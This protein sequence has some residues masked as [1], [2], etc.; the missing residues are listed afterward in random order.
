[1]QTHADQEHSHTTRSESQG[2]NAT[3]QFADQRPAAA[4]Q[5]RLANLAAASPR[6]AQ[7][8]AIQAMADPSPGVETTQRLGAGQMATTQRLAAEEEEPLQGKFAVAQRAAEEDE[9]PVQGKFATVQRLAAEE[10]EPLQGKFAIAQ[11]EAMEDEEPVQ[12]KFATAQRQ[13]AEEEE[14]LQG[15][16]A[17]AQRAAVEDEEPVQGKFATAQRQAAEEEEPLQGKFAVTQREAVDDEEPVQGMFATMQRAAA[18]EDE[19]QM[20]AVGAPEP[21]TQLQAEAAPRKNDTGLPDNLKS[22]VESLSGMSMDNVRV[23][24]NSSKPAQLNAYAYAQGTDIHVGPGQE[25]HL[26]HEAWHVVQQAQGRVKPTM[27]MKGDVPVNDDAG[28]EGEADLMGG[29]A[30]DSAKNIHLL[31]NSTPFSI[32]GTKTKI[33]TPPDTTRTLTQRK[34]TNFDPK[35][36]A[37]KTISGIITSN[38]TLNEAIAV[39]DEFK[40]DNDID[41][42]QTVSGTIENPLGEKRGKNNNDYNTIGKLGK[43]HQTAFSSETTPT[44]FNVGHL[45]ADRY[46]SW[47][48]KQEAYVLGNLS[49]MNET[50]NVGTYKSL[51]ENP[52]ADHIK[53][54]GMVGVTIELTYGANQDVNIGTLIDRTALAWRKKHDTLNTTDITNIRNQKINIPTFWPT[55]ID[56]TI[57]QMNIFDP[58]DE[59]TLENAKEFAKSEKPHKS[60]LK[61]IIVD[62]S[63]SNALNKRKLDLINNT[64]V[65]IT[66]ITSPTKKKKKNLVKFSNPQT[67]GYDPNAQKEIHETQG[68]YTQE[69]IQRM[70]E[71]NANAY[72]YKFSELVK[73]KIQET[74]LEKNGSWYMEFYKIDLLLYKYKKPCNELYEAACNDCALFIKEIN[75][76]QKL[77]KG[78]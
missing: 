8:R 63:I 37:T 9:E 67:V 10:E 78:D 52:I 57:K 19:L 32:A 2:A 22:G 41:R 39:P 35:P 71:T 70:E 69:Q 61:R 16:F 53:L 40:T 59:D 76:L 72:A 77:L 65:S 20:K 33:Y 56:A 26:P 58:E 38:N 43:F 17:V 29:K 62:R 31:F 30:Q 54:G 48:Q 13:A 42:A 1:M 64:N 12:G 15:K 36:I 34:V 7:L 60:T 5:N 4:S 23:H 27:Q 28:L 11:R 74:A 50:L 24:Y 45:L 51:N 21:A 68:R 6:S 75:G 25:K 66:D 18:E 3:S 46:F 49:P 73:Q 55:N 47:S 44:P 14:P